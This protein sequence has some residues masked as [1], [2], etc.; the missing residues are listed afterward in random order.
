M[1]ASY[2]VEFRGPDGTAATKRGLTPDEALELTGR[3]EKAHLV[4]IITLEQE[5]S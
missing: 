1:T 4:T 3:A 5:P 2:T